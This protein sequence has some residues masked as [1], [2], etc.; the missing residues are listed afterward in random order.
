[1]TAACHRETHQNRIKQS[2]CRWCYE[3]IP[4]RDFFKSVA[5]S[6]LTAVDLLKREGVG[7]REGVRPDLFDGLRERRHHSERAEQSRAITR[8]SSTA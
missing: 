5:D 7:G 1:M 4:L 2:V 6:G 3:K 8:R